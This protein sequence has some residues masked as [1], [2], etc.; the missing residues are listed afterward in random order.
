MVHLDGDG[1]RGLAARLED[2]P[3][4]VTRV[5]EKP[6]RRRPYAPFITSTLQQEAARKM[7]FSASQTMRTAQRL[8]ENGYITYMRT[9]SVNLSETA[10]TAARRQIAEL[11]GRGNVPP[12][13]RRYTGKVKNAQ[14]AHEAIRPAGDNFRTPGEVANE[15]SSDEFKLYELI[16]RRT[17]ASQ[18]TDAV[19]NSVERADPGDLHRRA[20]RSTSA[21]PARRSPTRASC[22]PTWSP[23]TT[24]TPRP[25]TPSAACRPWSRTS[26]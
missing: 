20:R 17:V 22:A 9:D 21:P 16:W 13:P 24:R 15:L 25:R 14:E 11:Y 26:R 23:R 7:R 1:A 12:Q 3:F 2:R 5:E 18:M 8:Y 6:Y 10:L 19:G 4:T